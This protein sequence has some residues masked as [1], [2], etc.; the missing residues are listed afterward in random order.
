VWIDYLNKTLITK[1]NFSLLYKNFKTCI[2]SPEV[3][4]YKNISH[5][6]K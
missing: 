3:A 6:K 1:K 4:G 2:V 5:I